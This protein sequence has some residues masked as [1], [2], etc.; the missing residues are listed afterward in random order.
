MAGIGLA[1]SGGGI[2]SAAFCSGVLRR[3]LD[4]KVEVD[5]LS[6][7]SGGG[8][9]GTAYLDWKYREERNKTKTRDHQEDWRKRFFAH[10]KNRAGYFCQ[11]ENPLE[12]IVHTII[13][14]SLVLL[15]TFIEPIVMWGSYA[16][17]IAFIFDY[18]FG[19]YLRSVVD[20]DEVAA[21]QSN[22][23]VPTLEPSADQNA[24]TKAIRDHCLDRQGTDGSHTIVLF[25]VLFVLFVVF[26]V[27]AKK[28]KRY[29]TP[30]SFIHTTFI[31][32]LA[33]TFFPF[34]IHDFLIKIPSWTQYLLVFIGIMVWFFLPVLR[35]KTSY[36]LIIYFYS[37]VIYWKV[38]EAK[39]LGIKFSGE[40]FN[41]LLFLSGFVL[42]V[43]PL[44]AASHKRLMHVYNRWRLQK[45]FYHPDGLGKYG[46][47]GIG[48][49][50]ICP[51]WLA[52]RS[53]SS[54]QR[55]QTQS[56]QDFLG[57]C[58]H[59]HGEE[60]RSLSLA[61]LKGI[62]PEYISNIVV[63]RWK[64]SE[65]SDEK[66][67]LLTMSSA[68][69]ERLGYNPPKQQSEG[70]PP[71]HQFSGK[72]EAADI[73]LSDAMATSAA[74]LSNHMGKYDKSV[75]GLTRFHTLLGLEMGATMISDYKSVKNERVVL[76]I[77]PFLVDIAR[78][79]PLI[80]V[81]VYYRDGTVSTIEA[82][83]S[84]ISFFVI[85]FLLAF[86]AV[87][88]TGKEHPSKLEK[89]ARWFTVHSFFA[90]Y[91]REMFNKNNCGPM[92]PPV[93]LLSD[94][95]HV[96]NLAL[97]PL[98]KKKLKKIIVVD[99]GYKHDEK[100]YGDSLLNALMLARKKLNCS[101]LSDSGGD[102]I[103]DLLEKFVKPAKTGEEKLPR[104]YKF[105][106]QYERDEGGVKHDGEIL[107]IVPR[108]P[109]DGVI[110]EEDAGNRSTDPS[111]AFDQPD[112]LLPGM[113][114]N[115]E[116]VDKL[117]FCCCECCHR[118]SCHGCSK[119]FC[120]AFPQHITANQFFTPLMFEAYHREGYRACTEAKADS[121]VSERQQGEV[122]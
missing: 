92:P 22:Q 62:K 81:P 83:G 105:K 54:H 68:G 113:F 90:Q 117:T 14:V 111:P 49:K 50:D 95:G 10:M 11:W 2:R 116:D 9:T 33:L 39:L 52:C 91:V 103:S 69:I 7:V 42:W 19:K 55:R 25:S 16:C 31:V 28:W 86:I 119:W 48:M 66:Y 71:K 6:C 37:Y 26:F 84:V 53:R 107:L 58:D 24:T 77:L 32:S 60:T 56:R 100:L 115:P 82:A 104:F 17:P 114:L 4:R 122:V 78:G 99:G 8:Y 5:Y 3:M 20:C 30:L 34:A 98:L 57:E 61:D 112:G 59:D 64:L 47:S 13:L 27:L 102:V 44:L 120:N 121:F 106:V 41:R 85:H 79:L 36:V 65:E 51:A 76:R 80:C 70:N 96:E 73:K 87:I 67:E 108:K 40:L 118:L 46:C 93:M 94:G 72:L 1:F 45:A 23:A 38:Y 21:A 18:L 43:V 12:G 74:A 97:L 109:E 75:E 88:D 15:I 101:F 35:S 89:L 110:D 63:N 29:S